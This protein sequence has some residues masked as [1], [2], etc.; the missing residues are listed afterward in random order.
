MNHHWSLGFATA[1]ALVLFGSPVLAQNMI[2]NGDFDTDVSGWSS[3]LPFTWDPTDCQQSPSSGS[4]VV[5]NKWST[6]Q[7]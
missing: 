3:Q 5:T 4:G 6:N 7:D 2:A 1:I